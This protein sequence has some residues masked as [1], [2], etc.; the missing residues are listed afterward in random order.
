MTSDTASLG[1]TRRQEGTK[2]IGQIVESLRFAEQM[3]YLT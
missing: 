3:L 1:D 2:L